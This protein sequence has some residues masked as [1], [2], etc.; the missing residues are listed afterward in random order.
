MTSR[1]VPPHVMATSSSQKV[2]NLCV[3]VFV[4]VCVCVCV[5]MFVRKGG[6]GE[7]HFE[8]EVYSIAQHSCDAV[9]WCIAE[10]FEIITES[11]DRPPTL[12]E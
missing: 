2:M 12:Y 7:G 5:C 8:K 9:L 11:E 1:G 10:S 6:G 3:F 4:F